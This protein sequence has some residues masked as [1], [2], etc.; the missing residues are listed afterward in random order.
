VTVFAAPG[1]PAANAFVAATPLRGDY[2]SLGSF[3]NLDYVESTVV[4]KGPGIESR[5]LESRSQRGTYFYD[6]T[7]KQ[8]GRPEKRLKT[9][10]AVVPDEFSPVLVTFTAQCDVADYEEYGTLLSAIASSFELN[11]K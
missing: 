4:P 2:T 9:I 10:F 5:C 6:Y 8:E 7:V 3:G 1:R 11:K